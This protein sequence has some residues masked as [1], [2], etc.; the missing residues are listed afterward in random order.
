MFAGYMI[1]KQLRGLKHML[2]VES[3]M[4]STTYALIFLFSFCAV[5]SLLVGVV[6]LEYH[7]KLLT[8]N[9]VFDDSSFFE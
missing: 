9:S 5:S 2:K 4:K 7:F 3:V 6:C 8:N 1:V